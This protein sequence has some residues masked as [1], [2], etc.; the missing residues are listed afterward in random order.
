MSKKQAPTGID[1]GKAS[2]ELKAKV[3]FVLQSAQNNRYSVSRI[4]AAHNAVFEL[5]E[6]PQ[7]CSTC[8]TSRVAKLRKW[9]GEQS[10]KATESVPTTGDFHTPPPAE[11]GEGTEA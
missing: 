9:W 2:E 4:Y 6:A 1:W 7:T 5:T 10:P 3:K 11:D 8:L